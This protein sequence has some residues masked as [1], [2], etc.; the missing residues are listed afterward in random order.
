MGPEWLEFSTLDS[1]QRR[2]ENAGIH[3]R[4]NVVD[5]SDL[6]GAIG[7]KENGILAM[8]PGP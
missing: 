6:P 2:L 4:Q 1:V 7:K 3:R 8:K 5:F